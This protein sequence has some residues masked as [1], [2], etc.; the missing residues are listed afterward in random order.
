MWPIAGYRGRTA[1]DRAQPVDEN[2]KAV[3]DTGILVAAIR[4][5]E[6]TRDDRL[7]VDP[8]ADRLAGEAG[9]EMLARMVA[10]V[11]DQST[12]QIVVRTRFWDEAILRATSTVSQVVI[13]AAGLDARA[14]RLPWPAD[15]TV[16][17]LDQPAVIAAKARLLDG[18]EPL[19]S[20]GRGRS[21]RR[22][23]SGADVRGSGT[24]GPA[25][26]L[27]E[28]LLQYLDDAAVRTLFARID[29]LSAPGS[30]LL[31]DVVGKTLLEA[32]FMAGCASPWPIG[33][34]MA[35]RHRCAR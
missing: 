25:V 19:P 31:Y 22:L 24:T 6:S 8:F 18:E 32:P 2:L 11:G 23:A 3:A 14:Y 30:I 12:T 27:I 15:A 28:G 16:F 10:E 20:G 1:E 4:A 34:A 29:A 21:G 5:H 35:F 9:R 33:L 7:F 26:W 13:L 17:E